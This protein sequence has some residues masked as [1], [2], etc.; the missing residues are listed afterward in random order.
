MPNYRRATTVGATYFFTVTTHRRQP[1]FAHEVAR[2]T[3]RESIGAVRKQHPFQIDAWVLLPDHLHCLWTMPEGDADFSLRWSLI[4]QGTSKQC[5]TMLIDHSLLTP[6]QQKNGELGF[7]QRRFWEHQIRDEADFERH[8]DYIHWNPVKH[9]LVR[10]PGEWAYS[11][12]RRYVEHGAYPED[13]AI[14]SRRE[15]AESFGE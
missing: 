7:W 3:L 2:R 14:A 5:A 8:A 15:D 1:L 6:T 9:G 4:K 13:W 11:T 10:S 12:F